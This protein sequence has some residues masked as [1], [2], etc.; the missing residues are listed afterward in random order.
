MTLDHAS[1]HGSS[2]RSGIGGWAAHW[3]DTFGW[4][5]RERAQN[6]KIQIAN[7]VNENCKPFYMMTE[8]IATRRDCRVG[9]Q[10][11]PNN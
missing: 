6:A 2:V 5:L 4:T 1:G 8:S 11:N 3:G 10:D 7:L 9:A